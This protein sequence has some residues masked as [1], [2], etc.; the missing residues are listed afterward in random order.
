[1]LIGS[2]DSA[3]AVMLTVTGS[4]TRPVRLSF[5]R[6]PQAR[7]LREALLH[8]IPDELYHD[9]LHG[10]LEWRKHMTLRLAEQ[11]RAELQGEPR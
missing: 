11:I 2:I 3:G 5:A 4:T 8:H 9:D 7:E 10:K 6:I 1:L